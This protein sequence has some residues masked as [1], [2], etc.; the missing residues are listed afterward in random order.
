[1]L[2][3]VCCGM[4]M[5]ALDQGVVNTSFPVFAASLEAPISVVGWIG[6]TYMIVNVTFLTIFGRLADLV[7]RRRVYVTGYGVFLMGAFMAFVAP[8]LGWL[9]AAR[10]VTGLGCAM[11]ISNAIA[12]LGSEL[13]Q[14]RRGLAIGMTEASVGVGL[15]IGPV[16]AGLLTELVGWRA[17]FLI[18]W[19]AGLTGLTMGL[20]VLR[21]PASPGER[22]TFDFLGAGAFGLGTVSLLLGLTSGS[23]VGWDSP[24]VLAGFCLA[25][26]LLSAFLVVERRVRHPMITLS[27]FKHRVFA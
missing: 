22:E 2:A 8:G 5:S 3:T 6:L 13:P 9:L 15:A 1:M 20:L 7:G 26:L 24:L 25:A 21:E 10:V 23:T 14:S 19:P 27:L 18:C 17:V 11:L 12:I 4:F 16:A